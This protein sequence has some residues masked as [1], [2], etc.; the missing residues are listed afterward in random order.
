MN[1]QE[2]EAKEQARKLSECAALKMQLFGGP[3]PETP[4][5][6]PTLK[7]KLDELVK[8]YNDLTTSDLQGC[9]M[10]ACMQEPPLT[11]DDD[12]ALN[13]IYEQIEK[14]EAEKSARMNEQIKKI[15][16]LKNAYLS[17][18]EAG[19]KLG[20]V[21]VDIPVVVICARMLRAVYNDANKSDYA[22]WMKH[23]P[24]LGRAARAIGIKKSSELRALFKGANPAIFEA[25]A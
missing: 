23:N 24:R 13:Y 8:A 6:S 3:Q 14:Q 1:K 12:D 9:V 18:L 16:A 19:Q 25:S 10:A 20:Q 17:S 11:A 2:F 7:A 5:F 4:R 21:A 15:T 22:D